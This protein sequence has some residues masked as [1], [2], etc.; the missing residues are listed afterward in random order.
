MGVLRCVHWQHPDLDIHGEHQIYSPLRILI[1][2]TQAIY[3][4]ISPGWFVTPVYGNN[5]FLF[6]S[7]YFWLCIPLTVCLSL[8][9]RYV[10][11]AYKT[12]F[13][14]DDV[15]ILRYIHKKEPNRVLAHDPQ[16]DNPLAAL[17]RS[18]PASIV[19]HARTESVASLPLRR[20][21]MDPRT[22]S[23]TDMATGIRSI[24]RGFDFA[25]EEN[26][27]AMRRIQTN[28]SER[29]E[30]SRNLATYPE[31]GR[32]RRETVSRVLSVPRNFLRRKGSN[33]KELD[34]TQPS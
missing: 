29:R 27:V 3:D 12:G 16:V 34:Q 33:T 1:P 20:P 6:H 22:C 32:R 8:L 2:Q 24:H 30:S 19:S 18:R 26:G 5:H 15:D 28:L 7:P 31:T 13:H 23:R 10:Y 9:P 21:S 25:T 11:K 17:R 14:P 4:L